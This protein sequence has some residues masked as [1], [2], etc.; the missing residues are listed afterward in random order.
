M[1]TTPSLINQPQIFPRVPTANYD[2]ETV[3]R[4]GVQGFILGEGRGERPYLGGTG[5]V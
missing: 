3:R 5:E 2:V 4:S 1:L